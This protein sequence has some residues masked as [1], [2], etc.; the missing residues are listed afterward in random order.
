MQLISKALLGSIP[1]CHKNKTW[2]L[3]TVSD[4]ALA[5]YM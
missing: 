1:Q 2:G 3:G 4:R 5:Q